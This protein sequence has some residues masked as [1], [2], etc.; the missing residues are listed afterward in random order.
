MGEL[1]SF[2]HDSSYTKGFEK[3]TRNFCLTSLTCDQVFILVR[4]RAEK[5]TVGVTSERVQNAHSSLHLWFWVFSV[6]VSWLLSL[7]GRVQFQW[8][9]CSCKFSEAIYLHVIT[10]YCGVINLK[11][12]HYNKHVWALTPSNRNTT[13]CIDLEVRLD[14]CLTHFDDWTVF[15]D[16]RKTTSR[17][18]GTFSFI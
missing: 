8:N 14:F 12:T 10:I 2:K 6:F 7:S 16:L 5:I 4:C 11:S 9:F 13:L 1:L 15:L 17:K 18:G 3:T